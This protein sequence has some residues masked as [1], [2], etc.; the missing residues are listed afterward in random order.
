MIYAIDKMAGYAPAL[1][2]AAFIITFIRAA[3]IVFM[4][5]KSCECGFRRDT[6]SV[7]H[8]LRLVMLQG[9]AFALCLYGIMS[10]VGFAARSEL[11]SAIAEA[12]EGKRELWI[13]G[14]KAP[15]PAPYLDALDDMIWVMVAH[16]SRPIPPT[17]ELSLVK[18]D[19][20]LTVHLQPDSDR[21][22]ELWVFF[23]K[24][25]TTKDND[26]GRIYT[27]LL[28]EYRPPSKNGRN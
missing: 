6:Y 11:K 21:S 4:H 12:R 18:K 1:F 13:D 10:L 2:F 5:A 25:K 26:I 17:I 7:T 20:S 28:L 24:Y 27:S 8:K 23:P 14:S 15:Q 19:S 16:H 22:N 3:I 9:F